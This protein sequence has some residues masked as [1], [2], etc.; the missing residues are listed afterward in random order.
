MPPAPQSDFRD[1]D[2]NDII[3]K[4]ESGAH[5]R[6]DD[7]RARVETLQELQYADGK[8]ARNPMVSHLLIETLVGLNRRYPDPVEGA[9]NIKIV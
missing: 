2:D 3:R 5:E 8:L 1:A 4:E 7:F 6:L 9:T